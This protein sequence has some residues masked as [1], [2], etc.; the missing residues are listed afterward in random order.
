MG[1]KRGRCPG[2]GTAL[3]G[4]NREPLGQRSDGRGLVPGT[5]SGEAVVLCLAAQVVGRR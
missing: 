1:P 4:A 2:A 3:A 5:G